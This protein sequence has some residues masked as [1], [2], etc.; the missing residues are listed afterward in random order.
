MGQAPSA[1]LVNREQLTI[2]S[3]AKNLDNDGS[4]SLFTD[5]NKRLIDY[6]DIDVQDDDV[7]VTFDGSTAPSASAGEK[8]YAGE[9][10]RLHGI[11]S[12]LNVQFIRVS[13]DAV[14]EVNYW[15]DDER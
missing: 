15:R 3:S 6:A 2:S 7:Y 9:K 13:T 4:G 11:E 14:L 1:L 10:Y 12:L 5:A 8:W